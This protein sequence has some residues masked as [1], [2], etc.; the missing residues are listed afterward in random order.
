[1]NGRLISIIVICLAILSVVGIYGC[2]GGQK[3]EKET[4][5]TAPPGAAAKAGPGA[6]APAASSGKEQSAAGA[7]G[8][9]K[10][11]QTGTETG[12]LAPDF[13]LTGPDG[14]EVSLSSFRGKPVMLNF[15]ATW[16]PPCKEEMPAIQKFFTQ[17]G[18]EMQV[19]AVNLTVSE[20][21]PDQVGDFLKSN[22]YT[23]PVLL[24]KKGD[25]A[26]QYLV[27]YIPT[28]YFIDKRGII[29]DKH[30]GP[31]TPDML[32]AFYARVK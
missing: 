18:Q 6:A 4:P 23:F 25:T 7:G 12:Q 9:E 14:K 8:Q 1:M 28:T 3:G 20:K 5:G 10:S 24:D 19:L 26:R 17:R 30:T 2:S 29:R 31:L 32:E 13:T 21:A 27:R 11:V 16:C 15:W 22:G